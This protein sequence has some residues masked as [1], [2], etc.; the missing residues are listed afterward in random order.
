MREG[1][2]EIKRS[3]RIAAKSVVVL[4]ARATDLVAA[5]VPGMKRRWRVLG[6]ASQQTS[7]LNEKKEESKE[8]R[9]REERSGNKKAGAR[10]N[11][12]VFKRSTGAPLGR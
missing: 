7:L 2:E 8:R 10:L 11:G 3:Q 12:R 5:D 4:L 1:R 9:R 6:S